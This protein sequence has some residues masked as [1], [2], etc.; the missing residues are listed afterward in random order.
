MPAARAP[1]ARPR[2]LGFG[3]WLGLGML[4][5]AILLGGGILFGLGDKPF[6]ID[7]AWQDF[8]VSVRG[9]ILR[10]VSYGMNWLGG[11]WFGVFVVPIGIA[12]LLFLLRRRW[13]AL[14]FLAAEIVSAVIV[15]RMRVVR[16]LL[17]AVV[18]CIHRGHN[19]P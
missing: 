12:A 8:L 5:A 17:R 1:F 7:T 3:L 2:G 10:S 4:I 19:T 13:A 14:Y 16:V 11:G 15:L 9:P 6:G 18:V